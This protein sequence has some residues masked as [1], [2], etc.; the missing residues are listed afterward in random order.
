VNGGKFRVFVNCYS[1]EG[2][3]AAPEEYTGVVLNWSQYADGRTRIR[4][5]GM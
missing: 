1:G 3:L 2:L 5:Q 4:R